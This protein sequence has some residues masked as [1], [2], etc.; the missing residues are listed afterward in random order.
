MRHHS[1]SVDL[2][3]VITIPNLPPAI[4]PYPYF[5]P[6]TR[7]MVAAASAAAGGERERVDN[8]VHYYKI[9]NYYQQK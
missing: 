1:R 7:T 5:P 6:P 2:Q 4:T 8:L 3:V 9:I